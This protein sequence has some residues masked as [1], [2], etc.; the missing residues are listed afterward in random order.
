VFKRITLLSLAERG[1]RDEKKR[2]P[3]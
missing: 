1:K 2:E 3:N